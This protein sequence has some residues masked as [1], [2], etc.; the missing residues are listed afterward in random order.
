VKAK[1]GRRPARPYAGGVRHGKWGTPLAYRIVSLRLT[2]SRSPFSDPDFIGL[3]SLMADESQ[4]TNRKPIAVDVRSPARLHLG[5]LSFGQPTVRSFGGVGVMVDR[6]AVHVRLRR[7]DRFSARGPLADRTI[8]FAQECVRAWSLPAETACEIEVVAA[9][10]AHVGLGSGTQLALAVAAG[11]R[12]LFRGQPD[13]EGHEYSIHPTE[14]EWL[15]DTPD[16][17]ELARAVGR[18]RRSCV[19]VYGFS[20]GGLIVEAGRFVPVGG[21]PP[22]PREF[23]PMVA[24]VRLPSSWRCLVI[25]QRDSIGLHGEP[26]KAAFA[27]LP[28]VPQE[29]SAE[30][31]RLALMDLLPAAVEGDFVMFSSAVHRY[32]QLAGRPF[33]QVSAALPHAASTAGLI[34]LLGEL[35]V[36]GAAQS[37][38]G[39]AVMACCESL[40]AA[41][42]LVEQL[43]ALGLSNQYEAI[44]ARYDS[45]GAVLRVLE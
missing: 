7:S 4:A 44:I 24:R 19:G 13:E 1:A 28:P 29:I 20:R 43:D 42:A 25:V 27:A 2:V 45:Q 36:R 16:A 37:S 38:W 33:E 41:G 18:G 3:L 22:G 32:G 35:G 6:P 12:H 39:P 11:M 40:D 8:G 31:A 5:M 9:P 30:L 17:L 14:H 15:F 10:R 23:S 34:E 26:E 21:D